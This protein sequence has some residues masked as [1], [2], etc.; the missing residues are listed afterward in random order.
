MHGASPKIRREVLEHYSSPRSALNAEL[1]HHAAGLL[2][3]VK[4]ETHTPIDRDELH[5]T[6]SFRLSREQADAVRY[7]TVR[8]RGSVRCLEGDAGTGKTTTLGVAREIWEKAGYK[9]VGVCLSGKAAEELRTGAKIQ[10]MTYA[11]FTWLLDHRPDKMDHAKHHANQFWR[12]FRGRKTFN[13]KSFDIGKNS[14]VVVDEAAMLDTHQMARLVKEVQKAGAMM[15][16]AGDRKQLQAIGPGGAFGYIA[17]RV[18][19]AELKTIVRQREGRDR[20][21]VI[22]VGEGASAKALQDLKERGLLKVAGNRRQALSTLVDDW[23][24]TEKHQKPGGSLIFANTRAEVADINQ[25]CQ[26]G[27]LEA[28]KLGAEKVM[29][30]G[31]SL[32]RNDRVLLTTPA[33]RHGVNNGDMGTVI[34]VDNGLK[35]PGVTVKLDR[36]QTVF[37]PLSDYDGLKLGY[38]V[39]THKGQGTTVDRAYLL[40]GGRMQSKEISYVQV[41]RTREPLRLYAV[42]VEADAKLERLA[43]AMSRSAEKTLAQTITDRYEPLQTEKQSLRQRL[44]LERS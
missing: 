31:E 36:G 27:L 41:S 30:G 23:L 20:Q 17:D 35:N 44:R 28:G 16:L 43:R 26:R 1:K 7:L 33:R 21:V 5:K 37:L 8:G 13:L 9:V 19:K 32:H 18:G 39:T 11:K 22:D 12:A 42:Q 34:G 25:K 10:A 24:A 4:R 2:K 29:V 14:V 38:A 3:A 6:S 40:A 15:V